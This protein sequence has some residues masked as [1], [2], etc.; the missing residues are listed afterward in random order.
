M[1]E[2]TTELIYE[3]LKQLQSRMTALE[4][5]L[6]ENTAAINAL[7]THVIALHQDV[8]NIYA[9]LGRHEAPLER[10]E[11]RLAIVEPA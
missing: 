6:R 5:G 1:V 11:R 2:V 9:V 8:Q 4:D 3:A 10:I 7:R